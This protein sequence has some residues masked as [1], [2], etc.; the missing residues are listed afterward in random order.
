MGSDILKRRMR[1]WK[2][3]YKDDHINFLV[4]HYKLQTSID[5]Y[6]LIAEEKLDL[7]EIRTLLKR[8]I[9]EAS[10][11]QEKKPEI[12]VKEAETP[13]EPDSPDILI[14]DNKLDKVNYK[15]AK[16]CN[17]IP[18]DPVF[19]FVTIVKRISIH[20]K[21]C[22]NAKRLLEKYGYRRIPVRWKDSDVQVSF[23]AFIRVLGED[24][25][26]MLG[27][28]TNVISNDL[29]V[30]MLSIK[31]DSKDGQFAG[32]IKVNVKDNVHLDELLHKISKIKGILRA[33]RLASE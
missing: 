32:E 4:K 5:L 28:I 30:N 24:R 33:V 12:S 31:V 16:C 15:L 20:S 18:G 11:P 9:S 8:R 13:E 6:D 2:I 10:K 22:P 26:G 21:R 19:G 14:I 1:N 25:I 7:N 3:Q 23:N 27:E 17:P 29:K